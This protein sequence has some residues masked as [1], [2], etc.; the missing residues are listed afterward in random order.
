MPCR[1]SP[2]IWRRRPGTR[3]RPNWDGR[4]PRSGAAWN[5]GG[6]YCARFARRGLTPALALFPA[7]IANAASAE[8]TPPLTESTVRA[9][10]GFAAGS[11]MAVSASSAVTALAQGALT[12]MS[13]T[14]PRIIA[15]LL[16]TACLVAGGVGMLPL[17]GALAAPVQKEAPKTGDPQVNLASAR[18]EPAKSD[19]EKLRGSWVLEE[20]WYDGK[21]VIQNLQGIIAHSRIVIDGQWLTMPQRDIRSEQYRSK[22]VIDE[23]AD[24]KRITFDNWY[25]EPAHA[26]Y[27]LNK[28]TFQFCYEHGS[29]NSP[30]KFGA[31]PGSKN[32]LLIYKREPA[33]EDKG[34]PGR[35]TTPTWGVI[36]AQPKPPP[37]VDSTPADIQQSLDDAV[38]A[39]RI[40]EYSDTKKGEIRAAEDRRAQAVADRFVTALIANDSNGM[41]TESSLAWADHAELIRD[42]AA[43][44]LHLAKYRVPRVFAEGKQQIA[45][46]ASLE[47]LEQALGKRV[48]E[49][50]RKT[51]ASHLGAGARIAVVVRGPM[52][53]ALSLRRT[54]SEYSVSGFLFDYFPRPDDQLLRAVT[55]HPA[56]KR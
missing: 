51:W 50:A 56:D 23:A 32:L 44:K 53:L 49:E 26:V 15:A 16:A 2:A 38:L 12:A 45:L 14:K 7:L 33:P 37:S 4:W 54:K 19:L 39:R 24:L 48:P 5:L 43:L 47:E 3:L 31:G 13:M 10:I 27:T 35:G 46:L 41:F 22:V 30:A 9:A 36:G 1:S 20:T 17:R 18:V 6:S 52:L 29:K 55:R 40:E 21:I 42:E 34:T 25:G 8:I 11:K 28:D